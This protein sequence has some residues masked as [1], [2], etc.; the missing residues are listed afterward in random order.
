MSERIKYFRRNTAYTKTL[1]GCQRK[2]W[3]ISWSTD[4]SR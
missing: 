2:K 3:Q 1:A 4:C